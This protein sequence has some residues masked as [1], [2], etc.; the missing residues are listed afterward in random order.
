MSLVLD[1]PPLPL[2]FDEYGVVRV[3]GTRIPLDTVIVA[4]KQGQTPEEIVE[5]FDALELADV[6]AVIG[7]YLRHRAEVD[8]YLSKRQRKAAALQKKLETL[9]PPD[10]IRERLLAR[11][12][13]QQT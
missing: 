10:G 1:A 2:A 7:Y 8:A 5:D 3:G 4:Y 9:F 11:R 13:Q 12:R 6:Y